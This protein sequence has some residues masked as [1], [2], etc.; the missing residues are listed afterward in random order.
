MGRKGIFLEP[1]GRETLFNLVRD[2]LSKILSTTQ[3]KRVLVGLIPRIIKK[4]LS[5]L[6]YADDIILFIKYSKKMC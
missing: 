1:I 5:H 4:G 2:S 6:Q 3:E